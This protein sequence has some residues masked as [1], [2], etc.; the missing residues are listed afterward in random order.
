MYHSCSLLYGL[1]TIRSEQPL[2]GA[3]VYPLRVATMHARIITDDDEVSSTRKSA[4]DP[5]HHA[6]SSGAKLPSNE[7]TES[8]QIS[9]SSG[10]IG[11]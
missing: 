11:S 3:S 5:G 1:P 2:V 9:S 8:V 4:A 6:T 7:Q 10:G